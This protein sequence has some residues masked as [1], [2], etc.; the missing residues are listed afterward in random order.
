MSQIVPALNPEKA[1]LLKVVVLDQYL[2]AAELGIHAGLFLQHRPEWEWIRNRRRETGRTPTHDHFVQQFP[3]FEGLSAPAESLAAI[4]DHLRDR[5]RRSQI[6]EI[7]SKAAELTEAGE[8]LEAIELL[9]NRSRSILVESDPLED[10]D[11]IT[12]YEQRVRA[13]EIRR[14]RMREG[15]TPGI[16][17]GVEWLDKKTS[18]WRPGDFGLIL[19]NTG[20]GKS[21]LLLLMGLAAWRA[22]NTVLYVSLELTQTDLGYRFD[23]FV[24]KVRNSQ[25]FKGE[26]DP[27][28]YAELIKPTGSMPPFIAAG[29]MP[30][31]R[32]TPAMLQAKIER[33]Q[34]DVVLLDYI[35]LMSRGGGYKDQ[36]WLEKMEIAADLLSMALNKRI[37]ILAAAQAGRGGETD[38]D[39][40]P[41]KAQIAQSYGMTQPASVILTLRKR[42]E[43][44]L[45]IGISKLRNFEAA[46][47]QEVTLQFFPDEGRIEATET[48]LA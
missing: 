32:F 23:P 26:I 42:A 19:G 2:E 6:V 13:M 10:V 44:Q 43:T 31:R 40:L 15:K 11:L 29:H 17:S 7:V 47:G 30:G 12:D 41:T 16:P 45:V 5:W 22:G 21:F 27:E 3:D 35:N 38:D 20:Q 1:I 24:Y 18:G 4:I 34:P 25:L 14:E 33:H 36:N 28:E 8:T 9:A 46:P 48:P 39:A 37:V